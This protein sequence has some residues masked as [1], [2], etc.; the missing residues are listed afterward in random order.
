M[1]L[2]KHERDFPCTQV[3]GHVFLREGKRGASWYA[4]YRLAD[5]QV[6]TRLGPAWRERSRPPHGYYTRRL[7]EEALRE[8]LTDA[9]RG[10]LAGI[11]RTG[12]TFVDASAEWLRYSEQERD[13]KPSTLI[14]YT[15]MVRQLDNELGMIPLEEITSTRL[16]LWREKWIEARA[17]SN[18]T[19]QKYLVVLGAIMERA[20]RVWGL[21]HN[22]A[23][24]LERPRVRNAA[25]I[26]VY[27]PEEVWALIREAASEQDAATYV[28]AAFVGLRMGEVLALRWRDVDFER[29]LIRV[30]SS[31]TQSREGTPKSNRMRAVPMADPVAQALARLSQ[32]P[33]F[34]EDGDLVLCG[35]VGDH[36]NPKK[37]RERYRDA[38][39][40]ADL[41]QLRFHDLRHVFGTLAI[42]RASAL[43]VKT[44]MGHADLKTTERYLHYRAQAD[45][46]ELLAGAFEARENGVPNGVPNSRVLS[47]TE[48]N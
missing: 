8:L 26:D 4:K 23:S 24:E 19:Q 14:D 16:E 17:P 37:V 46:A 2:T 18:R 44:W 40:A 5:R 35:V 22:P 13:V 38:Q 43:Q 36:L 45:E 34:T 7:A 12:A 27:V 11:Q 1:H 48:S 20:K 6:K 3:S 10:T 25:G 33:E 9:R 30:R 32:R 41:R 21:P 15:A 47:A 29:R 28:L 42:N 39:Q 31:Y